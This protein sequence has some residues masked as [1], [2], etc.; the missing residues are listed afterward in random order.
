M[1]IVAKYFSVNIGLPWR[2]TA[3][4]SLDTSSNLRQM[5]L[6]IDMRLIYSSTFSEKRLWCHFITISQPKDHFPLCNVS[7]CVNVFVM[8]FSGLT[9][10]KF[11]TGDPRELL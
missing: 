5:Y 2:D 8:T 1:L 9:A 7:V 11:R 4:I 10:I 3:N 6:Y